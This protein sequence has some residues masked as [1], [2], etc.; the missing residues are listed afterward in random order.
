ME[1]K[2]KPLCPSAQ[3]DWEGAQVFGV[4]GGTADTPETAYL[5]RPQP[6][7]EELIQLAGPVRPGEVFRIAARCAGG[8]CEHFS[9]EES[10]C[11]LVDKTVRWVPIVIDKL[12]PCSIR[13]DCL[14]W[15]QERKAACM[16]CPQVV[17]ENLKQ[18]LEMK[19]AAN[20]TLK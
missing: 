13:S 4:V 2:R 8:G 18:T 17:T 3:S 5:L 19:N 20:P 6:I 7:T 11:R 9:T 14:W 1:T 15:Q 16:R 12:P 10:K